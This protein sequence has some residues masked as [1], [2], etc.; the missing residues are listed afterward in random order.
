M[1]IT[2]VETFILHVPVTGNHI[3]DSTHSVTH[4]GMPGCIIRTDD[5]LAGYGFTGTHGHLPTDR[6]VTDCVTGT[7]APLLTGE[8]A[9]DVQRL[10]RKCYH[11]PP[12][13]WVG[14]CG[15]TQ[16]AL[17]AVDIALWDLKAKAAGLPLWRLLG[18]LR[19]QGIEAYNT[20]GG[21]LNLPAQTVVDN[22]KRFVEVDGFRGVKIKIGSPDPNE[23]LRRIAAVRKAI[24][25]NVKLMVDGNGKWD[26]TTGLNFGRRFAEHDLY[27]FE[28]PF[29]YDDVAGHRKFAELVPTPVALGEQL[30][31][32][33]PVRDFISAGAVHFVQPDA[34]RLGGVSEWLQVADLALAHRLP[35]AAHV[36]DMGQVHVHLS[37][38]HP[39]CVLLEY[40]PWI[41]HCFEEPATVRD[42]SYVAPQHPGAGTTLRADAL[43]SYAA[44]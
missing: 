34:V 44:S 42:G 28:E 9:H 14:R 26:L 25:P 22:C 11:F 17:A 5:G 27:W 20:D 33:D 1:K 15:I 40:I 21:W 13:Q 38:A 19:P 37:L 2:K 29:W 31:S 32:I 10:W 30:Y 24:G 41:R 6:L 36:G 18:G 7:Y 23:D 43:A 16:L 8:D 35:V 39:A 12:A 4:W 3:A